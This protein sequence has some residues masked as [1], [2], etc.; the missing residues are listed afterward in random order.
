MYGLR[1]KREYLDEILSGKKNSDARLSDTSIRGEIGLIDIDTNEMLAYADLIGT[2]TINFEEYIN[3]HISSSFD[4]KEATDYINSLD[5]TKL[6]TKAY[7]YLFGDVN[8]LDTPCIIVEKSST[9]IWVEF[10][11][12]DSI[13]GYEQTSLF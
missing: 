6:N 12:E 10:D 3:W 8:P 1:M 13:K 7:L 2:K 4:N 11:I 9:K 5:F